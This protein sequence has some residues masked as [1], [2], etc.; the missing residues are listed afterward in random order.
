MDYKRGKL[1]NLLCVLIH[2]PRYPWFYFVCAPVYVC[3]HTSAQE[4]ILHKCTP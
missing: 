4:R 3:T 2:L 1:E